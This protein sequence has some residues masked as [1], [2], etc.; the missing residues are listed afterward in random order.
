MRRTL[1]SAFITVLLVSVMGLVGCRG[2]EVPDVVGMRQDDAVRA[3][4][5][6]GFMLGEVSAVATNT[7]PLGMVAA[8]DPAAGERADDGSAVSLSISFSD[9]SRVIIPT[10]VGLNQVTAEQV[11]TSLRLTPLVVEQYSEG[12]PA[13]EIGAQVPSPGAEVGAGA[14]LVMVVSTGQA[15][16]KAKVPDVVGKSESAATDAVESAGFAVEVFEVFNS[17]VGKGNVIGQI[18]EAGKSAVVGSKVQIAVSLGAGTGSAKVPSVT[19]QK[20]GAASEAIQNAGLKVRVLRDYDP[21]IAKDVVIQQ[22]PDA[23]STA[24]SGSEVIIVVSRGP[25]PADTVQVPDVMGM[26]TQAAQDAL[27]EAGF[28]AVVQLVASDQAPDTVF[29]QFPEAG[30]AAAPGAEIL[31]AVAAAP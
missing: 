13:G 12:V 20:E 9:G 2:T 8:Q 15:P 22:F 1:A 10:V 16:D 11:A 18:P 23:G 19:G 5:D 7:V 26:T 28:V 25:E 4:Q 6:A 17:D 29:Y 21:T 31:L 30:S 24:A 3:L 14:T 27:D